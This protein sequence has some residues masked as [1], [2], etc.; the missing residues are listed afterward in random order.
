MAPADGGCV[1]INIYNEEYCW[2][3][4]PGRTPAG[5]RLPPIR[6]AATRFD[7][8]AWATE[9]APEY[10]P[11]SECSPS[12]LSQLSVDGDDACARRRMDRQALEDKSSGPAIT[13]GDCGQTPLSGVLGGVLLLAQIYASAGLKCP[14]Q[15]QRI[16]FLSAPYTVRCHLCLDERRGLAPLD[17]AMG[18][19][20]QAP[21]LQLGRLDLYRTRMNDVQPSAA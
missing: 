21:L 9:S 4:A 16:H 8:E 17:S 10:R 12:S 11:V 1:R 19:F 20:A 7:E 18:M 13:I 14:V 5:N 2:S 15:R 6:L 3:D